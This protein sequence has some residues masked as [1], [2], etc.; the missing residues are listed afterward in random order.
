MPSIRM[1]SIRRSFYSLRSIIFVAALLLFCASAGFGAF[2]V[3][4]I[5]IINAAS[6]SIAG[7]VKT[8]VMLGTMKQSGQ[9]LRAIA[10][11]AHNAQSEAQRRTY[12]EQAATAQEALSG[13]WS[14]YASTIAGADERRL[15]HN[16]ERAW[17]HFL[18]V[19]AEAAALDRAG[20]R[21]LAETVVTAALQKD[22]ARFTRAVDAV[23]AFRQDQAT[24]RTPEVGGADAGSAVVAAALAAAATLMGMIGLIPRQNSTPDVLPI[25]VVEPPGRSGLTPPAGRGDEGQALVGSEDDRLD[26]RGLDAEAA[27]VG[28]AAEQEGRTTS[29]TMTEGVEAAAGGVTCAD[30]SRSMDLRGT[31]D[32]MS[33]A[34]GA[35]ASLTADVAAAAE[36]AHA[37]VRRVAAA[38]EELNRCVGAVG[39]QAEMTAAMAS[40]ATAEARQTTALVQPLSDAADR[41]GDVVRI[42]AKIAAQTNLLALNAAIEA[43]RAGDAGRGFAVVAAEVKVLAGQTK[44][45]TEDIARHVGVIQGST[46]AAAAAIAG[47]AARVEDMGRAA[48]SIAAAVDEQQA[49]T[50]AMVQTIAQAD[51]GAGEVSTH[52]AEIARSTDQAGATAQRHLTAVSALT[53]DAGRLTAELTRSLQGASA[54]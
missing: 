44:Q 29:R 14:A 51:R 1:I 43:A 40:G 3:A 22:A 19:Q 16:L 6:R 4:H 50:G 23:L 37:H 11:L 15:A 36:Q 30:T 21:E 33:Q 28:T 48:A 42:I 53:D 45:A 34:A 10:L 7:D 32:R 13:A 26:A 46:G 9:E 18:A 35:T 24:N 20:E 2:S 12:L 47:I 49:I 5:G 25:H 38:T 17:Q 31:A 39:R 52:I 54:A 8:L 41:I 27:P